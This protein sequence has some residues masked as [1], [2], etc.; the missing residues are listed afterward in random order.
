RE[1]RVTG[2][3]AAG[4]VE[5]LISL[6][7]ALS[8]KAQVERHFHQYK[9]LLRG[10]E[11]AARRAKELEAERDRLAAEL[12]RIEALPSEALV[13]PGAPAPPPPRKAG[14][15]A[16]SPFREYRSAR[17]ARIL[18]GK[19]GAGNDALTFGVARPHDLWLHARGV[20]GSHVVVPLEKN[21]APAQET[22]LDAAHLALHHSDAKGEPRGEVSYTP[23]KFVHRQRGGSP[24]QVTYTREKTLL[25]RMEPER[26]RRLLET[27]AARI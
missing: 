14:P 24:G 22:L 26:L 23:V 4:P 9:R 20:P 15:P 8:P 27:A 19:S 7:P 18:V 3:T 21:E 13:A 10:C 16:A 11:H 12:A 6:D 2:Y 1:V 17:G 25:V 5:E